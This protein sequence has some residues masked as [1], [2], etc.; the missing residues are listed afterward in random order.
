M[1]VCID[2]RAE[3][4]LQLSALRLHKIPPPV[5]GFVRGFG[6]RTAAIAIVVG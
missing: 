2:L 4:L 3:E 5:R 6:R 1:D